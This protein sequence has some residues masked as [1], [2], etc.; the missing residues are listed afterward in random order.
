MLLV[1]HLVRALLGKLVVF[2]FLVVLLFGAALAVRQVVSEGR[3]MLARLN[4]LERLLEQKTALEE[5]LAG[6]DAA[7]LEVEGR[8]DALVG[9]LDAQAE[10]RTASERRRLQWLVDNAK[11]PA[12]EAFEELDRARRGAEAAVE[13]RFEQTRSKVL[14]SCEDTGAVMMVSCWWARRQWNDMKVRLRTAGRQQVEEQ[15]AAAREK[16]E[17]ARKGFEDA[18]KDFDAGLGALQEEL[19][20]ETA[21]ALAPVLAEGRALSDARAKTAA[22][23]TAVDVALAE[24]RTP[25]QARL[26]TL[27]QEWRALRSRV[28][29]IV[30]L[31]LLAPYIK[32]TLWYHVLLRVAERRPPIQLVPADAEG[33]AEVLSVEPSLTIRTTADRPLLVRPTFVTSHEGHEGHKWLYDWRY[34][35]VSYAAGLVLLNRYTPGEEDEAQVL[36]ADP[37]DGHPELMLV[38]LDEHPGVVLHPRHLVGVQ[39]PV[40]VRSVWRFAS[41]HAWATLQF[42][43]LLFGGS[44]A[45]IVAGGG[46]VNGTEVGGGDVRTLQ[47]RVLGFDSRLGYSTRRTGSFVQYLLGRAELIE[48]RHAGDGILLTQT[49]LPA[50]GRRSPVERFLDALLGGLGKVLGF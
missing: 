48:D 30:L 3:E 49:A 40:T 36:V 20:A 32:R 46:H 31:V 38:G 16:Y 41:V 6:H 18:R 26:L 17:S 35:F 29:T 33:T 43:Y 4:E 28:L 14:E 19:D 24:A 39:G 37:L 23:L 10:E 34:P 50:T 21:R 22:D 13:Y 42:R 45:L 44:G 5:E 8:R 1:Y 7:M 15:T 25:Q 27:R 11:G 9:E 12:E 2:G 47:S